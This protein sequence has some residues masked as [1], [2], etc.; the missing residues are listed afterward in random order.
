MKKTINS[1]DETAAKDITCA[2][3]FN[4]SMYER[5]K[6]TAHD[7]NLSL[8]D[9]IRQALVDYME[10]HSKSLLEKK[11]EEI[12]L[13]KKVTEATANEDQSLRDTLLEL[14]NKAS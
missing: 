4:H 3:R 13:R 6:E 10:S 1:K 5:L 14:L 12:E 2:V 8:S 9:V 7:M 11:L